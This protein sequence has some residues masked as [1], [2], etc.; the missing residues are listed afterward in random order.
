MFKCTHI[1]IETINFFPQKN[2]FS[3]RFNSSAPLTD[4]IQSVLSNSE[5]FE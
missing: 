2:C 1:D 4:S 5:D 3:V